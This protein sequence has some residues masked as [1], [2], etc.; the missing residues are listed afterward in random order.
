MSEVIKRVTVLETNVNIKA[1]ALS[2]DKLRSRREHRRA[3][4]DEPLIEQAGQVA[5]AQS[6]AEQDAGTSQQQE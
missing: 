4:I 5:E 2:S 1:T 6:N 3:P